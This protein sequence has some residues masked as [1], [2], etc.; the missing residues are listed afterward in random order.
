[1]DDKA[2]ATVTLLLLAMCGAACLWAVR[3]YS[4]VLKTPR[5]TEI[6][7]PWCV[8]TDVTCDECH[9]RHLVDLGPRHR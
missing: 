2:E 7:C 9:G 1:M 3:G 6:A 4:V 5:R 8:P